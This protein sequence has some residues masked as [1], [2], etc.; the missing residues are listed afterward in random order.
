MKPRHIRAIAVFGL[1]LVTLTGARG[2]RGGGCDDDSGSGSSSSGS[3]GFTSGG[4]HSDPD[5]DTDVD[6]GVTTGGGDITATPTP[7][8]VP[9]PVD[10]MGDVEV[11]FCSI[12]PAAKNIR[13][14]LVISNSTAVSQTYDITVHFAGDTPASAPFVDTIEDIT[15][16][17]NES[18]FTEASAFYS[19]SGKGTDSRTCKVVSATRTAHVS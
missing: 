10:A 8:A 11:D 1:V 18:Y 9:T 3:G 16:A 2:S 14:Q 12:D 13:G 6:D 5:P 17:G 15:V 7:T 4:S 19:G